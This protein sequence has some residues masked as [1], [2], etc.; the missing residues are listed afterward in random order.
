MLGAV[1]VLAFSFR[2]RDGWCQSTVST[3]SL[4]ERAQH[5]HR[6]WSGRGAHIVAKLTHGWELECELAPK[7]GVVSERRILVIS[8]L[9]PVP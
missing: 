7:P 9:E 2:L 1:V 3:H 8:A 4:P 5:G 6:A